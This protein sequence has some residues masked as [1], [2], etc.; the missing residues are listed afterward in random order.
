METPHVEIASEAAPSAKPLFMSARPASED[1]GAAREIV[2]TGDWFVNPDPVKPLTSRQ[3]EVARMLHRGKSIEE[4]SER[5]GFSLETV[6]KIATEPKLLAEVSRLAEQAFE[7]SVGDRVKE[8]AP[9][10]LDVIE[11][12]LADSGMKMKDRA[13][14]AQWVVEKIDGKAAQKHDVASS[15]LEKFFE[16]L[17]E[18]RAS[19]EILDVTPVRPGAEKQPDF[20]APQISASA[21]PTKSEYATWLDSNF[22]TAP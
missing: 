2:L 18:M 14:L 21:A 7:P 17:S 22:P 10:A 1:G 12:A 19:G 8:I 16:V 15:T 9:K 4:I 11:E 6:E 20:E 5:I 3:K 13:V